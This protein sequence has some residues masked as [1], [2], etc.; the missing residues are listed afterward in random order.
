[1]SSTP[2]SV[3]IDVA[4]AHLDVAVRPDGANWQV[5]NDAGGIAALLEQLRPLAPA[6]VVLEASGGWEV[7]AA[8]TLAEAGLPVA[9]VNPRQVRDFARAIGQLA[10]TDALDARVL[11][12]FAEVVRPA[13][14]PLPDAAQ[15][16]LSAVL[17]RRRQILSMLV[18]ERQRL[19]TAR[20]P[21]RGR[22][23]AHIRWL[24]QE[25]A[26]LD[27][28]LGR[29]I[30][31]SPLWREREALLRTVPGI[32]PTVA[33]TLLADLPEL[34]QLDRKRIATLVGLA[35]LNRDSGTLRGTRVVWGARARVRS[36]R[37]MAALVATRHNPVI[38]G[39]FQRL[40][41]A[42]KPKLV[43]LTACMH[44]LLLILNA[45]VRHH[46]PWHVAAPQGA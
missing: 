28:E 38:R 5:P 31:Q 43:A 46:T 27:D 30:R 16:A 29:T 2:V 26:N 44:T 3:G 13:P 23:Q 7:L 9:V 6:L 20:P 22:V 1:M 14:R 40:L 37:Y 12:R 35:P 18:A 15:Q 45:L 39:F 21:V 34:G 17:A 8:G 24:E 33:R 19:G 32:G 25:L 10:K 41:A 42:G 11:A 4:K 36:A